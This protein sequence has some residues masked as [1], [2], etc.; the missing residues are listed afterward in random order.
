[1]IRL[2]PRLFLPLLFLIIIGGMCGCRTE[3]C[4]PTTELNLRV[5]PGIGSKIVRSLST[6]E[7]LTVRGKQGNWVH[8]EVSATGEQGWV[9]QGN[10][11]RSFP[12]GRINLIGMTLS[13]LLS[14]LFCYFFTAFLLQISEGKGM[15]SFGVSNAIGS[16]IWVVFFFVADAAVGV[17]IWKIVLAYSISFVVSL[18]IDSIFS[19][20]EFGI[21]AMLAFHGFGIVAAVVVCYVLMIICPPLLIVL[22]GL[23]VRLQSALTIFES[24]L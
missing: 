15:P 13:A 6:S 16:G 7:E 10:L 9:Y 1:M 2:N 12:H 14:T 22:A 23:F 21:P 20:G 5:G 17:P 8:V 4:H 18:G 11:S 24:I 19:D 3:K